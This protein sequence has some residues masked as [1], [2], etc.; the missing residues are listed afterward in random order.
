MQEPGRWRLR[1]RGEQGSELRFRPADGKARAQGESVW[2]AQGKA[3]KRH[4][5]WEKAPTSTPTAL[6]K[7]RLAWGGPKSA[8]LEEASANLVKDRQARTRKCCMS[9]PRAIPALPGALRSNHQTTANNKEK[10][11]KSQEKS[12]PV[13]QQVRDPAS[14]LLRL[15]FKP[16]PRNFPVPGAGVPT[17]THFLPFVS[18]SLGCC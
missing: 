3:Q 13:A 16:W 15:M 2:K 7:G 1:R 5:T 14:S 17:C 9:Q 8:E 10:I 6:G 12:S 11:S 18:V 4:R